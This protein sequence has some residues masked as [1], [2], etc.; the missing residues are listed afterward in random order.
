M[1]I[2]HNNSIEPTCRTY[3]R[4]LAPEDSTAADLRPPHTST[5]P[6]TH[7]RTYF[8]VEI[9]KL[10]VF[11]FLWLVNQVTDFKVSISRITV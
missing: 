7:K 10:L 6:H 11:F 8:K 3:L 2:M 5:I 4:L 9:I 1:Y